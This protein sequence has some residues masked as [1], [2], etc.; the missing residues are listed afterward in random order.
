[1][2]ISK[3]T[4]AI[5]CVLAVLAASAGIASA[6][7]QRGFSDV[8]TSANDEA[9]CEDGITLSANISYLTANFDFAYPDF[10]PLVDDN[11][12]AGTT[13]I[14]LYATAADATSFTNEIATVAVQT[15]LTTPGTT[16]GSAYIFDGEATIP[17]PAGYQNG[18]TLYV[19]G[20]DATD[21]SLV[22]IPLT[23]GDEQYE[24]A[25]PEAGPIHSILWPGINTIKTFQ[26]LP[27]AILYFGAD[28]DHSTVTVTA[29][30]GVTTNLD[31]LGEYWGLGVGQF[32]PQHAGVTCDT[33]SLELSALTL[34]GDPLAGS[35]PVTVTQIGCSATAPAA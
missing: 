30:D 33:T 12:P 28:I 6:G 24:C 11:Y 31:F 14:D 7:W 20:Y 15:T 32:K 3:V 16:P 26:Y 9:L 2:R 10:D 13:D 29:N 25:E 17:T 34:D 8:N 1:M 5:I 19:W 21:L 18:D 23:I 35:I 22:A 27:S 4:T